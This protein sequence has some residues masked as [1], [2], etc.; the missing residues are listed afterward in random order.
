[1]DKQSTYRYLDDHGIE[2]EAIEHP[3][4]YTM[5]EASKLCLPHSD[6]VAKNLFVTDD[7]KTRYYLLTMHSR[8]RVNLK[9]I[10]ASIGSRRLELASEDDLE[11]ILHVTRGTVGPLALLDEDAGEVQLLLDQS[12]GASNIIGVHPNENTA[13]IFMNVGDLV[14]LLE[15]KGINISRLSFE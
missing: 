3:A 8:N 4:I 7:K 11:K 10:R 13:T 6:E 2:Y 5:E 1:M 12:F 14:D 15:N 9:A